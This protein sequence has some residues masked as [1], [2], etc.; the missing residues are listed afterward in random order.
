VGQ[1]AAQPVNDKGATVT[2]DFG[3]NRI[4]RLLPADEAEELS[5]ILEPVTLR[6][7]EAIYTTGKPIDYVY[8]PLSGMASLVVDTEGGQTVEAA[9]IG[10][11]GMVGLS[12]FWGSSKALWRVLSQI[13]GDAVRAPVD[14]FNEHIRPDGTLN[15]LLRQYTVA[16]IAALAQ[17]AACN[18]LHSLEERMCRWLL[19]TSDRLDA[20]E[21]PLTQDFLGQMLGVRRPSVSLA[22]AALQEAGLIKY[23]RGRI[24][25]VN[26]TGLEAASCECYNI[27]HRHHEE[28]LDLSD[29]T[30]SRR[31]VEARV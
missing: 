26:R 10:R 15:R 14:L 12:T 24:A 18:R 13:A 16:F 21:F 4:L 6:F 8:F 9:T 22:G 31:P 19:T 7:R 11:E 28:A 3:R 29:E 23:T 30:Y 20:D 25:I 1:N 27:V 5:R 2:S 17:T